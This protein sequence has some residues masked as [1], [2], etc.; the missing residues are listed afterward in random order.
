MQLLLRLESLFEASSWCNMDADLAKT[1]VAGIAG[2][3]SSY[4]ILPMLF[5][6]KLRLEREVVDHDKHSTDTI[7]DKD[8]EIARLQDALAE[9]NRELREHYSTRAEETRQLFAAITFLQSLAGLAQTERRG[10]RRPNE[11]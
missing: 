6:G 10:A 5:K 1:F 7:S 8:K 3:I 9:A 4:T 2:G 11:Q